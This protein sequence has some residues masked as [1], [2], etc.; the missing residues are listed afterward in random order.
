MPIIAINPIPGQEIQNVEYLEEKGIGIWLKKKDNIEEKLY[1][2]LNSPKK[3]QSMK[4][5][6]RLAA[7]KNSTRDICKIILGKPN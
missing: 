7:K 2:L 4:I 5:R 3:L 1:E 6:A